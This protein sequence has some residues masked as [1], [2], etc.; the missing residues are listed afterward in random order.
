MKLTNQKTFEKWCEKNG[1]RAGAMLDGAERWAS[2]CDSTFGNNNIYFETGRRTKRG[3]VETVIFDLMKPTIYK[4]I[5][6]NGK[7][8]GQWAANT[9]WTFGDDCD[10]I[11]ELAEPVYRF[12]D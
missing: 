1:F 9:E 6:G 10:V 7:A 5:D 11:D 4:V 8:V 12:R 2:E 3:D